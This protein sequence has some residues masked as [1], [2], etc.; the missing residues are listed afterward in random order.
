MF[1]YFSGMLINDKMG[2]GINEE[3]SKGE[4]EEIPGPPDAN[5]EYGYQFY[6]D[7]D[8]GKKCFQ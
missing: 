6:E 2:N 1:Q 7:D 5:A 3:R 4:E 8:E